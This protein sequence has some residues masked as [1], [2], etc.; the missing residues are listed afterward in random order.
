M[1]V[2]AANSLDH[3]HTGHKQTMTPR[4]ADKTR[5]AT[6]RSRLQHRGGAGE[7]ASPDSALFLESFIKSVVGG[8]LIQQNRGTTELAERITESPHRLFVCFQVDT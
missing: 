7:R 3:M 6:T 2:K 4:L 1:W 5:P 8:V